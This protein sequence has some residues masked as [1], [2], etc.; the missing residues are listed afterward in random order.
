MAGQATWET[1]GTGT[2]DFIVKFETSKNM[3]HE[4][5]YQSN[6]G[7]LSKPMDQ[8]TVGQGAEARQIDVGASACV[9][10]KEIVSGDECRF[11]MQ[12]NMKGA[13]TFGD[14]EVRTG[15]YLA[16]LNQNII[17]NK[18]DTP[19]TPLQE[20]MSRQ[21]VKE[22]IASPESNI[23]TE[24]TMYL[25]EQY[26][27]DSLDAILMGASMN[28]RAPKSEGG[29]QLDLGLG[30]GVQV[31]PENF[32]V[33]G[34]GFVSGVTGTAGYETNLVA[35][36]DALNPLTAGHLVSRGFVHE[37]RA[38]ITDRKV[39]GIQ[40][41]GKEKWYCAADPIIMTRLTESAGELYKNWEQAR[42]RSDKNPVFGHGSIELEDIVFFSEQR[43]KQYRPDE[44]QLGLGN[45]QWGV[46]STNY[47]RREFVSTS[48]IVLAIVMGNG[49]LLEG[50]NGAVDVTMEQ[51]RHGKGKEL[52][53]HVKQS[54]M[55][56][57][58]TPKDGRT[59][60]VINQSSLVIAWADPGLSFGA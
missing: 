29:R 17:L 8:M 14:A 22:T 2:N 44:T 41:E 56:A 32:I 54:F 60:I 6:F 57:R 23:R 35:A 40:I 27:Y 4:Y 21:R 11:T 39:K 16:Y 3:A 31:S 9:W 15:D 12:Q 49:T 43:L 30:A 36:L 25:G 59:N 7:K 5:R 42:E 26:T 58:W 33:A 52:A 38:A 45:L 24:L 46:A 19:A 13:P 28:L 10:S 18:T 37:V 20:E 53:G 34:T 48:T 51:G 55:R 47:D 1:Q 50:H